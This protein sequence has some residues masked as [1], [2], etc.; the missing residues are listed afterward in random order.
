MFVLFQLNS[1]QNISKC[2]LFS[3][4]KYLQLFMTLISSADLWLRHF[5]Q[6]VS[7]KWTQRRVYGDGQLSNILKSMLL[8]MYHPKKKKKWG[9]LT[10]IKHKFIH[11]SSFSSN[12]MFGHAPTT[13]RNKTDYIT[14][15]QKK[16]ADKP[17]IT[18]KKKNSYEVNSVPIRKSQDER[19][20]RVNS[21]RHG[22]DFIY[23]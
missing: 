11:L 22:F 16:S 14:D 17:W 5:F 8:M 2:A 13:A 19:Q 15:S 18:C 9:K 23:L 20:Q 10:I 3:N 1:W 7:S 21:Y 4:H 12:F 6:R